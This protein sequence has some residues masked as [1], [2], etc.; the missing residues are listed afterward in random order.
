MHVKVL[1]DNTTVQNTLNKM[2]TSHSPSL[3]SLIKTIWDWCITNEVWITVAHIPG[4]A[5]VDADSES[6]KSRRTTEWCLDKNLF[7][8]ACAKLNIRPNINFFASRINYQIKPYISYSSDQEAIAINA[9]HHSWQGYQFYAFP[10]FCLIS[11]VLQKIQKEKSEG[12]VI[13]PKT[14]TQSWWPVAMRMLMQSPII[15]PR[16]PSIIFLPS[17]PSETHPLHEK[18][19]LI[20]CHLSGNS[21]KTKG[22]QQQLQ[23]SWNLQGEL[24]H[25]SNM[26]D[27]W[28][29]GYN[30]VVNGIS[31]PF[32][33]L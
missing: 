13:I 19:V 8:S 4:K 1:V 33:P 18:L 11:Q 9:F 15:L 20:M 24:V 30:I 10:P 12:L 26:K 31:I 3:N 28:G 21:S 27:I 5:N 23:K 16:T 2:G 17:N 29:D 25:E 32:L 22:F 6:R 14:P 7:H